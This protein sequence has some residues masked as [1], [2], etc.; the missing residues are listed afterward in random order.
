MIMEKSGLRKVIQY[1]IMLALAA[2][3]LYYSFKGVEWRSFVESLQKCRW[4][5]IALSM[6]VGILGFLFRA[7]RWRLIML[8]F[9][10]DISVRESYDGVTIAY[11]T[12]FVF[13][14]AGEVARCGVLAK[15]GKISFES[16]LGTVVLERVWDMISL[17]FFIVLVVLLRLDEFGGFLSKNIL[18]PLVERF[19]GPSILYLLLPIL[20]LVLL[21]ILL[22][23][24]F[25]ARMLRS[26]L[27][28]RVAKVAKGLWQ[29]MLSAFRMKRKW[30]FF[31]Y[32]LGLWFSYWLTSYVTILAFPSVGELTAV[33]ALFLMIVGGLGWVV[34]VQGGL[35]AYHFIVSLALY[36]V[37]AIPQSEGVVFA[38]I[39]HEA[40]AVIMILCGLISL[41]SINISGKRRKSLKE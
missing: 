39:S 29:G 16:A 25:G 21:S 14:R 31:A 1:V 7:L 11:A 27:G 30:L 34:P 8:P 17:L 24:V 35:G 13:P 19:S 40:Q 41:V 2:L 32:T 22:W 23:R 15:G 18:S 9:N 5:W 26:K 12:N 28:T 6:L 3:L 10:K 4:G 37:Y 33:D 20:A 36:A 38:T